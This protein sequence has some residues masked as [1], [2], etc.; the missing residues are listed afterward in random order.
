MKHEQIENE[1]KHI[2]KYDNPFLPFLE[3]SEK[4]D[5]PFLPILESF[6][7]TIIHFCLF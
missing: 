7:N 3:S 6:E 5:N 2:E 1:H 4:Y